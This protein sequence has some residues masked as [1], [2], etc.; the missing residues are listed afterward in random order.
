MR[1]QR[2]GHTGM[3]PYWTLERVPDPDAS[4]AIRTGAAHN[5]RA[6]CLA[7]LRNMGG[8]IDEFRQAV[9]ILP[10]HVTY[11]GNLAR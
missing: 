7:K 2:R 9:Q 8:A 10:N 3:S 6:V 11:R 5:Q 4:R 1:R